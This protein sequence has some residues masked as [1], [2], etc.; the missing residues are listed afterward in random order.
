MCK[1]KISPGL[2][3]SRDQGVPSHG[4]S[5]TLKRLNPFWDQHSTIYR[6]KLPITKHLLRFPPPYLTTLGPT[7]QQT[8]VRLHAPVTAKGEHH[9]Q[10]QREN[11]HLKTSKRALTSWW[12]CAHW[13]I[14][15]VRLWE[16]NTYFFFCLQVSDT[17]LLQPGKTKREKGLYRLRKSF[18]KEWIHFKGEL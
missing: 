12:V 8:N 17:L 6:T 1:R 14:S 5:H 9:L 11:I 18:L 15:Q 7:F 16:I 3:G 13:S 4:C 2:T 10:I